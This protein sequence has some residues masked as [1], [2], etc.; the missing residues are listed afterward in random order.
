MLK[1]KLYANTRVEYENRTLSSTNEHSCPI[2]S[3]KCPPTSTNSRTRSSGCRHFTITMTSSTIERWELGDLVALTSE[4]A[5]IS[6]CPFFQA[7]QS[8]LKVTSRLV[9]V[10]NKCVVHCCPHHYFIS[11][12]FD[13][14]INSFDQ[15]VTKTYPRLRRFNR[16]LLY[17]NE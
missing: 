13:R 17:F 8:A 11:T 6:L 14:N 12:D 7:R 9:R 10:A 3:S 2:E 5:V 4:R 16:W 15:L 1:D